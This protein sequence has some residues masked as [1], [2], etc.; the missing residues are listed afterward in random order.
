MKTTLRRPSRSRAWAETIHLCGVVLAAVG[1]LA[2]AVR[3]D[4]VALPALA[5]GGTGIL[6]VLGSFLWVI[7][8]HDQAISEL[9]GIDAILE[10]AAAGR[11]RAGV[12]DLVTT[13]AAAITATPGGPQAGRTAIATVDDIN[14]ALTDAG[15]PQGLPG[16][17]DL[18]A[19]LRRQDPPNE[20]HEGIGR[21]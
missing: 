14:A 9:I 8:L 5:V 11:G 4:D 18:V 17:R 2:M 12:V 3:P 7:G 16:I 15:Y 6:M 13:A 1:L 10:V 21:G 20:N 19:D